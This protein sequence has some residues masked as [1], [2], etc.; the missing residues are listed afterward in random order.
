MNS[1]N[2][3]ID[4]LISATREYGGEW[5]VQHSRRLLHLVE[6][7]GAGMT[8][9]ANIIKIAA[10][11]HDW[12]GYTAWLQ[13]GVEHQMRSAEVA[14]EWLLAHGC[15]LEVTD[16]VVECIVNHHGGPVDRS[17]ES[18]LLTDADALELLGVVGVCRIFA[19]NARDLQAGAKRVQQFRDMS[20][21]AIT[22][23]VSRSLAAQRQQ[24]L[25]ALMA[26]FQ[27]ETFGMI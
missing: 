20:L 10:Y 4:E 23:D 26:T 17:L 2:I 1:I 11:L 5:A 6:Q 15:P 9:N 27:E 22:L 12:G 18:R 16:R 8:Y 19:M 21:A 25:D 24:E 3:S 13:P 7:L 14:R